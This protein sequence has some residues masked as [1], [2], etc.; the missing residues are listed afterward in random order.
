MRFFIADDNDS[1]RAILSNIIEDEK[2]GTVEGETADGSKVCTEV[3]MSRQIDILLLDLL[4]PQRDGIEIIRSIMPAYNGK[5]VV[6]SQVETKDLIGKAF[7]YGI[8]YYI[9]KPI[10]KLE[11]VNI[12]NKLRERILLENSIQDIYKRVEQVKIELPRRKIAVKEN[13]HNGI[14]ERGKHLLIQLGV[15]YGRGY[16]ELLDLLEAISNIE[17]ERQDKM[18]SIPLKTLFKSSCLKKYGNSNH[19]PRVIQSAEQ[20][21]RRAVHQSL[22]HIAALGVEDYSNPVFERFAPQFFDFKQIRIRMQQIQNPLKIKE[23]EHVHINIK[24]FIQSLYFEAIKKDEF[25]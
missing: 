4:M 14:R 13:N 21:V 7:S 23:W 2:L 12:V 22:D 24:K 1:I 15:T 3:L 8:D 9:L 17:D 16:V 20:S 6:I 10:N 19:L 25:R 11:I 5:V 18:E